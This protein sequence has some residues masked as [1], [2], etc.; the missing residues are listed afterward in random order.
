MHREQ[1]DIGESLNSSP[2]SSG[3]APATTRAPTP[4]PP[5]KRLSPAPRE[6]NFD[7]RRA[8]VSWSSEQLNRAEPWTC[9]ADTAKFSIPKSVQEVSNRVQ[10]NADR[11]RG[12]YGVLFVV[13]LACR[14]TSS[15]ELVAS[16]A[17]VAAVCAAL[18]LHRNDETAAVL[19]TRLTLG[20]NQRIAAAALVAFPL[21]YAA[22]LWSAVT[23]SVGV[24]VVI[25]TLHATFYTGLGA[26]SKFAQKLPDIPEGGEGST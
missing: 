14:V 10:S 26:S 23:W 25:G 1:G 13:I 22:D 9:F 6:E 3:N 8:V 24:I 11:F 12:N 19:G 21:L 18:K 17:A 2:K 5:R 7:V 4:A 16:M 20:K 15:V